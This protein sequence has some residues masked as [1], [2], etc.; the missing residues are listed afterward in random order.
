LGK[1]VLWSTF[2][3]DRSKPIEDPALG[4]IAMPR[5]N[6]RQSGNGADGGL[7]DRVQAVGQRIHDQVSEA[8]EQ[9]SENY[10][11]FREDAAR[12][13]RQ[14]E[15]MMARNPNTSILFG[16]G[17]GFGL[18]LVLTTL[19]SRPEETWAERYLPDRLRRTPDSLQHLADSL[20]GL[21]DRLSQYLPNQMKS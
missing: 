13:Y 14:A 7:H 17:L 8:G 12:R 5:K 3:S 9:L 18:G 15:G 19:L 10:G 2:N 21:P 20:K 6:H 16:L 1:K 11:Q 4:V